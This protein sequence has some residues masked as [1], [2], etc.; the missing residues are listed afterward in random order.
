[1]GVVVYGNQEKG[2][3]G[4]GPGLFFGEKKASVVAGG[5]GGA[6]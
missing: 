2:P 4:S 3:G 1:M 5:N 6:C